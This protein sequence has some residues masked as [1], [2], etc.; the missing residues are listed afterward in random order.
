M[1]RARARAARRYAD[2]SHLPASARPDGGRRADFRTSVDNEWLSLWLLK[3]YGL[4]VA[5]A[6]IA[7]FGQQRVLVVE[8]FDRRLVCSGQWLMR[9]EQ[10]AGTLGGTPP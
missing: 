7:T 4:P 2:E 5:Y 10:A 3:A 1:G 9:L 8:R 6:R